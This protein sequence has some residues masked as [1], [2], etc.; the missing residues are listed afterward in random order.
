[1]CSNCNN[2]YNPEGEISL[3]V[4]VTRRGTVPVNI[5]QN[6]SSSKQS[7]DWVCDEQATNTEGRVQPSELNKVHGWSQTVKTDEYFVRKSW[8]LLSVGQCSCGDRQNKYAS[9]VCENR[10][11]DCDL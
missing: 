10:S 9:A 3:T 2:R 6:D 11:Q 1:M 8:A 4:S 7:I 5:Q